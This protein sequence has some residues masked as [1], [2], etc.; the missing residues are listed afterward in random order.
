M[1]FILVALMIVMKNQK[2]LF[3]IQVVEITRL[4]L[5]IL[6]VILAVFSKYN[7]F[8]IYAAVFYLK[9]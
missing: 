9:D 5:K 2:Q 6:C 4:R 8:N 1:K 7:V 3:C